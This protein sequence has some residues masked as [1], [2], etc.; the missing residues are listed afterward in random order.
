MN[1]DIANI[2]KIYILCIKPF[3]KFKNLTQKKKK[4]ILDDG[5]HFRYVA[6]IWYL[7]KE[8]KSETGYNY[9]LDVIYNFSKWYNGYLLKI[10]EGKEVLKKLNYLQKIYEN[11]KYNRIRI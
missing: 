10:K 11:V 8:I 3:L 7:C 9:V 1:K 4:N 6:D 2:I 5:P